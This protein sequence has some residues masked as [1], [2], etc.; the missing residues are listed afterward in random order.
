MG[1]GRRKEVHTARTT[2][3]L[4]HTVIKNRISTYADIKEVLWHDSSALKWLSSKYASKYTKMHF[5]H[6]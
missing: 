6:A 1:V 3:N 4:G 2:A 5:W